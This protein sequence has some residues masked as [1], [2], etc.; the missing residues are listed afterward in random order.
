MGNVSTEDMSYVFYYDD[1]PLLLATGIDT[2][3]VLKSDALK[4]VF[5]KELDI[6]TVNMESVKLQRL[7]SEN[8]SV[9]YMPFVAQNKKVLVINATFDYFTMYKL[10]VTANVSDLA[11]NFLEKE[12]SVIFQTEVNPVLTIVSTSIDGEPMEISANSDFTITFG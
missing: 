7:Y 9:A 3:G 12:Y 1:S 11:G 8:S 5:N 10:T 2:T 4:L 6:A